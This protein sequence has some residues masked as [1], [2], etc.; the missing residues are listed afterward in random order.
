MCREVKFNIKHDLF[1]NKIAHFSIVILFVL[2]II[3]TP[4]IGAINQDA[5]I[6]NIPPSIELI[7]PQPGF[8]INNH[9]FSWPKNFS[10]PAAGF[11]GAWR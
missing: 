9:I 11:S 5:T 6:D 1:A 8:R 7:F 2:S 10:S 4:K 3:V